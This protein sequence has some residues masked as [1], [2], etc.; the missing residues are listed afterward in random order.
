MFRCTMNMPHQVAKLFETNQQMLGVVVKVYYYTYKRINFLY[1]NLLQR[2]QAGDLTCLK[3]TIRSG[4]LSLRGTSHIANCFCLELTDDTSGSPI[5]VAFMSKTFHHFKLSE[6][7][8]KKH[9]S[10][11]IANRKFVVTDISDFVSKFP[12]QF[13]TGGHVLCVSL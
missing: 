6:S 1:R 5:F 8:R 2:S 11:W 13:G 3:I 12:T 7:C 9:R 4:A 10:F